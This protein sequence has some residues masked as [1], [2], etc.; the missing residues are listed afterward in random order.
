MISTSR[1]YFKKVIRE[2]DSDMRF[3]ESNTEDVAIDI[4]NLDR[5]YKV[6]FGELKPSYEDSTIVSTLPVEV[7]I[8]K[9]MGPDEVR[10]HDRAYC[11][12][13]DIHA[14]A[15]DR[16]R[17]DQKDIM[18]M[19]ECDGILPEA[20]ERDDKAFKYTIQFTVTMGYKYVK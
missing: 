11:K 15:Q 5:S 7:I 17:L 8:Y 2:I 18:K 9:A 3:D 4:N 6:I 20:I 16:N 1:E 14:L 10:D 19:V 12:A 13:I